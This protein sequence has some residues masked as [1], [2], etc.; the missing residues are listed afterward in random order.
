M[1]TN[2]AYKAGQRA[3]RAEARGDEAASRA[4][5]RDVVR[6]ASY[7]KDKAHGLALAAAFERG[8]QGEEV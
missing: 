8:Y 5:L 2:V 3:A 6:A 7:T 1:T 4:L